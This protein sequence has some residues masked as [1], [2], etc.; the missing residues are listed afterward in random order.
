MLSPKN[1]PNKSKDERIEVFIQRHW[2]IFFIKILSYLILF[3]M[4]LICYFL[5]GDDLYGRYNSAIRIPIVILIAS[6]YYLSTWLFFSANVINDFLDYWIITN[7]RIINI[8]QNGLFSRTVGEL[9][10]SRVQDVTCEVHGFFATILHYGDINIQS[11][12]TRQ[13]FI[14][15]QVPRA[16]RIAQDVLRLVEKNKCDACDRCDVKNK[17]EQ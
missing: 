5:I 3:I 15:K 10:L 12:G 2:F 6:I 8:N 11:A 17:C 16:A 4:P 1:L 7:K 13:P 9:K 14:F